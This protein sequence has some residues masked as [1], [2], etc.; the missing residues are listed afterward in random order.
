MRMLAIFWRLL[1]YR[2]AVMLVL[3]MLLG[4]AIHGQITT[5]SWQLGLAAVILA[6]TYV[7]A[8]SSNDL[9]DRKIDAINHP[10]SLGRPLVTGA[11]SAKDMWLI[12]AGASLCA[13][14]LSMFLG[15]SAVLLVGLSLLINVLYSLPPARL[16]Y[17]TFLAP[18]VLGLAYV[19]I[20]YCLGLAASSSSLNYDDGVWLLGLYLMF[21]GRIILKDFR[22]R[23]GDAKYNK[24][25]F[26]LRYGKTTTCNLSLLLLLS[27][28]A[29]LV[30][31]CRHPLWLAI[32]VVAFLLSMALMLQRLRNAPMGRAEQL[33]IGVGAKMG[34]GL[35]IALL[36]VL[37]L[38]ESSAPVATQAAIALGITGLFFA[39]YIS[40]WLHPEQAVIGYKG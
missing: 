8:T 6:L 5:A 36:A 1:R 31:Q 32:L 33:S 37:A 25:T 13:L 26:L 4:V 40:F 10:S 30:W 14:T 19:G 3:F 29:L 17:R 18:L 35:L 11:A 12:F 34:N 39:G 28:G 24:P 15:W 16:S 38:Q 23:K 27:G 21:V 20:P 22:D 9:A 7:S 2:V